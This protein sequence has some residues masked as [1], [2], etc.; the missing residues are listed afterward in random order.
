MFRSL[1]SRIY[2]ITGIAM[3]AVLMLGALVLHSTARSRDAYFWVEHTQ[4][5]IVDLHIL[6]A[7]LGEAE[8]GLRGYLLSGDAR[9]LERFAQNL[10]QAAELRESIPELV[11]DNPV[12]VPRAMHLRDLAI[13]KAQL[14][15]AVVDR[16]GP[17]GDID[18]ARRER[19]TSIMA[20]LSRT[21]EVMA[22][23]ERRLLV[24]RSAAAQRLAENTRILMIIGCPILMLLIGVLGWLMRNSIA[25][26][27]SE[28]L[29]V[30]T[31]FG[32]GEREARAHLT[33]QSIEF[34]QLAIAYNEMAERLGSAMEQQARAELELARA[35]D[36]LVERGKALEQRQNSI[37]VLSD[38]AHRLQAIQQEGELQQVLDCYLFKVF[39][40]LA[41]V[42]YVHNNS[43]NLL[44]GISTWGEPRA[45][46]ETFEPAACW[47]LRRGQTHV[48]ETPGADL[49]C[50]HAP[51][52]SPV[53]RLCEP[54]LAGG[55]VLGLLYLEGPLSGED[56]F[57]VSMLVENVALALVND[58]LRRRL[59]EQSIRDPLTRLFNRRYMEEALQLESTRAERS[60]TPLSIVMADVDHFKRFNDTHGH[61]AGDALLREVASLIEDHFRRGDIVCRY[62]GEEFIIIAPG[63]EQH[64]IID[65]VEGLRRKIRDKVIDFSG[66]RLGP[67]TMSFGIDTWTADQQRSPGD[68]VGDA[69]RALFRAKRLG[70]DR[71][72]IANSEMIEAAE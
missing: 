19:A 11:S 3:A 50:A 39:P 32:R 21:V 44:V 55:E 38:M 54:L 2:A 59:R 1:S 56:R 30:V 10:A 63:A 65:R 53:E 28:L 64:Q 42:L 37:E 24:Q 69:D 14:M 34:E 13:A 17:A 25:V 45:A 12:Q 9:Y 68:L 52:D 62:G 31:R 7:N 47:A 66:N 60:G 57:R 22:G 26:P 67:V 70:R 41:G 18:P 61:E 72:E 36:A 35:N 4:D 51:N 15:Q 8:S 23:E 5:V 27:L 48:V 6:Q 58:G 29:D 16:A 46:H 49:V 33:R 71:F 40:E 43:R 20:E